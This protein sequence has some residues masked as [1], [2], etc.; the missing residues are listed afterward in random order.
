MAK[1]HKDV[2][3]H[4]GGE[5]INSSPVKIFKSFDEAAGMALAQAASRGETILDVVIWSRAGAKFYGGDYAV[6]QY[7]E[8]PEASVFERIEIRANAVGRVA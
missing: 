1:T 6:E 2:E 3:Y 4:V 8:D 5:G 7:D